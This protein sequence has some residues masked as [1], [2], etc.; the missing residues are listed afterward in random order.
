M[1]MSAT[2]YNGSPLR[3]YQGP[4]RVAFFGELGSGNTGND[5]SFEVVLE[6]V[7]RNVPDA[8]LFAICRGPEELSERFGIHSVPMQAPLKADSRFAGVRVLRQIGRKTR[9]PAWI[10]G[11]LRDTDWVI[12]SGAGVLESTW[13]RPWMLPY[14]LYGLTLCARGR[15]TRV[16]LINVG[17]DRARNPFTRWLVAQVARRADYLTLRDHHSVT[18]LRSLD[19]R[20]S[21]EQVRP[22]LAF[23]L[24]P[25]PER[26][27]RH[28][29][30]GV[31]LINYFDWRGTAGKRASNRATYERIMISFIGWLLEDGYSVRLLTGDI[32]DDPCLE[33]VLGIVRS[34][35]PDLGR[36]RLIG[37]PARDL[38]ELMKQ[39]RDV[40]VV[41]GAR[42]HNVITALR[43]GKPILALS[44][45]PKTKQAMEMFGLGPFGH[46][47]DAIDLPTLKEQFCQLYSQRAAI[48]QELRT[49]LTEVEARLQVQ[50]EEFVADFLLSP[51]R[52]ART[53]SLPVRIV[54]NAYH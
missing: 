17:A 35:H 14:A 29:C 43:L 2:T 52:P 51:S 4:L 36:D 42:Y 34:R 26:A 10:F 44:Y 50:Q 39:M 9:D 47:L 30:V 20:V 12:V 37:E 27:A 23:A 8:E 11:L 49:K 24:T 6:W 19:V 38:H 46:R 18:A 54:Q 45:A 5:G 32:W 40:E 1:S 41:V 7:R 25:P 31:G 33:R 22:D 28:P 21:P 13:A 48:S 3:S 53:Q 16:A 15:G